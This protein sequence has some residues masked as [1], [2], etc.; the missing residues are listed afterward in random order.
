MFG[1][2]GGVPLQVDCTTTNGRP[3]CG[4]FG[5]GGRLRVAL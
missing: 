2:V 4:R 1:L 3:V 5:V